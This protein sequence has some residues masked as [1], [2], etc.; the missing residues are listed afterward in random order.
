MKNMKSIIILLVIF[1]IGCSKVECVICTAEIQSGFTTTEIT[2]YF[3]GDQDQLDMQ[4]AA[5]REIITDSGE[6]INK[7][8]CE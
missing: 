3:C 6:R 2:S 7:F 8:S 1:C 5:M 4:K